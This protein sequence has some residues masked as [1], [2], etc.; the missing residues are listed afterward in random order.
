MAQV[1]IAIYEDLRLIT[2][3]IY[4]KDYL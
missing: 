4:S 3:L 2:L 1:S